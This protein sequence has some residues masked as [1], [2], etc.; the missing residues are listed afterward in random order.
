MS[1]DRSTLPS[2]TSAPATRTL[3]SCRT[4]PEEGTRSRTGRSRTGTGLVRAGVETPSADLETPSACDESLPSS[5]GLVSARDARVCAMPGS[6]ASGVRLLRIAKLPRRCS[7]QRPAA[8]PVLGLG[9]G[10]EVRLGLGS[11]SVVSEKG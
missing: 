3:S 7:V 10:L 11:G 8:F 9:L 1:Y 6:A 4:R 2:C 5:S